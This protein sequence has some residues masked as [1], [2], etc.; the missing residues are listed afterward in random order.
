MSKQYFP[1]KVTDFILVGYCSEVHGLFHVVSAA[2][3]ITQANLKQRCQ[4]PLSA[5]LPQILGFA[6]RLQIVNSNEI[7][8][9]LSFT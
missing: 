2:L 3:L 8:F 9:H 5:T 6:I 1:S 7:I 4:I